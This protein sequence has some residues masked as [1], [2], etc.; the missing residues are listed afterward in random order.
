MSPSRHKARERTPAPRGAGPGSQLVWVA[1]LLTLAGRVASAFAASNWLWGWDTFRIWPLPAGAALVVVAALGFS[2]GLS[3]PIQRLLAA[4][5]RV[6]ERA[7]PL[8]DLALGLAVTLVLSALHDDLRF[9]GDASVRLGLLGL[10]RDQAVRLLQRTFPLDQLVNFEIPRLL[11]LNGVAPRAALQWTGALVGGLFVV[12]GGGLLRSTGARGAALAASALVLFGS[13]LL[14]HFPGYDKFGPLMVGLALAARG[15][16][17]LSR[18]GRGL[19]PLALGA[20]IC[21]ASHRSGFLILPAVAWTLFAAGRSRAGARN[22]LR[23]ALASAAIAVPG[24]LLL[25]HVV[26][27]VLSFDLQVHL[28]GGAVAASRLDTGVAVLPLVLS[29]GLNVLSVLVPL[30]LV[31]AAAAWPPRGGEPAARPVGRRLFPLAPAVWLALGALA[32]LVFGVQPGGGWPRDWDVALPT[33]TAIALVTASLLAALWSRDARTIAPA[34]TL[35][36]ATCVALWGVAIGER[37]GLRRAQAVLEARP[38]LSSAVRASA[39]DFL[40]MRALTRGRSAEAAVL[41]ERAIACAPN[42]RFFHELGLAL[43]ASG[44]LE[45]ARSAFTRAAV[46]SPANGDPWYGLARIELAGGD[47]LAARAC[48]DSAI[49]RNPAL[50][51]ARVLRDQLAAGARTPQR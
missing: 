47:A 21:L 30:W 24:A 23:V 28:P 34:A 41:L 39:Y 18:S 43:L 5:G 29:D 48:L 40:G 1:L 11:S 22:R 49:L 15:A 12:A 4:A 42:P 50:A 35:A 6:W 13:G 46:L 2:P 25:P 14:P 16:V 31:G 33:A 17:T 19:T 9:T 8:G 38:A 27:R 20:G 45:R 32:I 26:Q 3:R 7:G 44:Q 36:V 10:P 51:E 37:I